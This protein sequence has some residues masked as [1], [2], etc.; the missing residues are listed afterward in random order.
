MLLSVFLS[1]LRRRRLTRLAAA[2][3]A[4]RRANLRVA[5]WTAVGSARVADGRPQPVLL[6]T[7]DGLKRAAVYLRVTRLQV[8]AAEAEVAHA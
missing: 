4:L 2:H 6:A 3:A 8:A 5:A 7:L 1:P